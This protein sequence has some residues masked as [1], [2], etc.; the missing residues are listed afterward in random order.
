VTAL[1]T[2]GK[3]NANLDT[4]ISLLIQFSYLK[5][6]SRLLLGVYDGHGDDKVATYLQEN[7]LER[8]AKHEDFE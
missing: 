5:K 8:L 7:L 1:S 6:G 2:I 3:R 4:V